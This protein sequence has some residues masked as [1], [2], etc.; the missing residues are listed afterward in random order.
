MSDA[1]L[2]PHE[3]LVPR[4]DRPG[5]SVSMTEQKRKKKVIRSEG[6]EI[7]A[8]VFHFLRQEY[9]FMKTHNYDNCDL[10]PLANIT[11]RTA[12][13]T[14]VGEK[15]VS[16]ILKEERN[17]P[18]PS[19]RFPSPDTSKKPKDPLKLKNT[20]QTKNTTQRKNT[21]KPKK[22]KTDLDEP[23]LQ[24]IR[25]AIE[26][27]HKRHKE[28]PSLEK[29]KEVLQEK[30]DDDD[31]ISEDDQEMFEEFITTENYDDNREMFQ[32]I[33]ITKTE[34]DNHEIFEEII[35]PTNIK[36]E[37]P[38]DGGGDNEFEIPIKIEEAFP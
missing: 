15:L 22:D 30:D 5:R 7:I 20:R 38:E 25:D 14:G 31:E 32:E 3:L 36:E 9:Q 19:A 17:L 13:A 37:T 8:K 1:S 29:L 27:Y 12:E 21:T 2:E 24:L 10:S 16:T 11:R 35:I 23:S 18:Y 28:I 34:N 26:N 33:P 4:S 6:R